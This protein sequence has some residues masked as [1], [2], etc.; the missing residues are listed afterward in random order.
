MVCSVLCSSAFHQAVSYGNAVC[1]EMLAQNNAQ[2]NPPVKEER[3][4]TPLH[5][6]AYQVCTTRSPCCC[7]VL[8]L[9]V[10]CA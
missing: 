1:V 5:Y 2:L 10:R 8:T 4:W 3:G 6:A 9:T 7:C